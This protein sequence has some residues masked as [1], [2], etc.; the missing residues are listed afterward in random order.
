MARPELAQFRGRLETSFY[1]LQD[2]LVPAAASLEQHFD[3]IDHEEWQY[4]SLREYASNEKDL[5][6]AS[7][8]LNQSTG[9]LKVKKSNVQVSLPKNARKLVAHV[10][11]MRALRYPHLA[12]LKGTTP[13]HFYNYADFLLGDFVLGLRAKDA[14]DGTVAV[15]AFDLVLVRVSSA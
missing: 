5:L 14:S 6:A 9:A 1:S 12:F 10:F 2:K 13:S 15:P 11:V 7:M 4:L 8:S 3:M